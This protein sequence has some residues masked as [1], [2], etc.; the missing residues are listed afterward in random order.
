MRRALAV[1]L[2]A[3][4][5][6]GT[7]GVQLT[8]AQVGS[9]VVV[10][11]GTDVESM[12]PMFTQARF[13]DNVMLTMFETLVTRDSQMRYQP[14]LAESWRIISP[15]VWQFRLRKG[16]RFHDGEPFNAEAVKYTINRL[17]DPALKAPSFLKGFVKYDHIDIVDDYTLNIV[18]K[19][20]S[21]LVLEWL[22]YFYMMAP[23]YYSGV[24]EAQA[25]LR[26]VGTGPYVFKEWIHDDH[27]TVTAN[28]TYWGPKPKIQTLVFR[29][30]PE[31]GTR[32]A[33]LLSGAADIIT[34]VPPDQINRINN[35]S[36]AAV[37]TV[38]GG[39]D[40]FIGMRTD[41][42]PFND[43]R[44]RQAM[45]YAV[46]VDAILKSIL[47]GRGRR[48]AT[49]VNAYADP[50]VKPYPYDPNKAKSLLAEAG[51]KLQN[52]V[53]M[54]NGQPFS[55][56]MDTPVGRYI[57]DKEIAEATAS[58]LQAIGVQVKVNPLAWPVYSKKMFEDVNPADMYLLGLGSSFDGQDE[59]RYVEKDFGYNPTYWNNAE[60]EK[61]YDLLNHTVDP[62]QRTP[63]LYKLQEIAHDDAPLIFLYKQTDFYGVNKRL[64]WAPRADE[65]IILENASVK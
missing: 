4:M 63:I 60:F 46:D 52:N 44:V 37:K 12:D 21:P 50:A 49:L 34:N 16:V 31:A 35:S 22:V 47:S 17:Y 54:K 3:M 15:T 14:R 33:D 18:M 7:L 39:R 11:Q 8:S 20:T 64:N 13:S 25:S 62:K 41:R 40:I 9:Q 38:E 5:C 1:W 65:L 10:D 28:P 24:T 53:L 23:K 51:W 19:E 32:I 36:N 61:Q 58:Y 6:V 45:N 55:V 27:V 57:S 26:P 59:I 43:T 48:M 29:P 30:V 56:T 2:A 42:P